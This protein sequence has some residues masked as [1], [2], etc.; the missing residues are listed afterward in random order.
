MLQ[1]ILGFYQNSQLTSNSA[2]YFPLTLLNYQETINGQ[3]LPVLQGDNSD[4]YYFRVY[5]NFNLAAGIANALNV[6]VT[7]WDGVGAAS[8]LAT[9]LPVTGH[10][11]HFFE[12]G[13]GENSI[14]PGPFTLYAGTDT[15]VGGTT[16]YTVQE[17][18]DG[19]TSAVIDAFT[20]NDGLGYIEFA[21]YCAVPSNAPNET[22]FFAIS[23]SY[24]YTT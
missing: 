20:N 3:A 10:W 16:R 18:S 4:T 13:Y 15:P 17:G 14:G 19:S 24:E 21:T 9:T 11:D 1:P 12:N 5:N 6:Q 7:T 23:V 22:Y 2:P 8:H